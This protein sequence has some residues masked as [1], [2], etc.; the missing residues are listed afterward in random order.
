MLGRLG[1]LARWGMGPLSFSNAAPAAPATSA[2]RLMG[3]RGLATK[4]FKRERKL[5]ASFEA[6]VGAMMNRKPV[7]N[8][9]G[10]QPAG[11]LG[12]PAQL[13][14]ER[15]LPASPTTKK[16]TWTKQKAPFKHAAS[17]L[18][19]LNTEAMVKVE[20][21]RDLP[22]FQ[23]GDA[24]EVTYKVSTQSDRYTRVRGMVLGM[25]RNQLSTSF[26]VICTIGGTPVEFIMPLYSPLIQD[27]KVIQKAF[28]HR[29]RKRVRR[30][31]LYYARDLSLATFTVKD[32]A[33]RQMR[34][35]IALNKDQRRQDRLE[36]LGL[37][38][39]NDPSVID[40]VPKEEGAEDVTQ[41][42][43]K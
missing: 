9:Y 13:A 26:R 39:D 5:E 7:L 21:A 42:K 16:Y 24:I 41:P 20:S 23:S 19:Q 2:S 17:L 18:S 36:M 1:G 14:H 29:A 8:R 35:R 15:D 33:I 37:E 27:I 43:K 38:L 12:A 28:L 3:L 22:Y 34:K 31:K 25:H 32:G 11:G 6:K 10:P 40:G 30:A 4:E